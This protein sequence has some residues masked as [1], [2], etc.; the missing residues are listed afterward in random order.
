MTPSSKLP[1][2]TKLI[3]AVGNVGLLAL[4][5]SSA[6]FLMMFYTDI[7]LVPPAI[8]ASALLI[9]KIW[10]VFNDP[11][12]GYLSDHTNSRWGRRRVYLVYG[13]IPLFFATILLWSVPPGLTP[14]VAFIWI[15]L[16]YMI[17]DTVFTMIQMPFS[18]LSAE[19]TEDYDERTSL[20]AISMI[21]ALIGFSLGSV[22]MPRIVATQ[23]NPSLGYLFAG[24][25]YGAIAGAAIAFVAWRIREPAHF[26]QGNK[27]SLRSFLSSMRIPFS[28]R[29]FILLV[30]AATLAR[31]GLTLIQ[32][33][34]MYYVIYRLGM[35]KE[36]VP[37]LMGVLMLVILLFIFVWKLVC[38]HWNKHMAY[39]SGLL[40]TILSL[41]GFVIL[42]PS[43]PRLVYAA[44]GA[45]GIGLSA[46][47][48]APFAMLPDAVDYGR[49]QGALRQTGIY[50]AIYGLMDK[51]AR[52]LGTVSIGWILA[53]Y[54]YLPNVEQ[55]ERAQFGIDLMFGYLPAALLLLAIP[56][57]LRYPISRNAHAQMRKGLP[58]V[59][60]PSR[61][62]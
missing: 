28:N 56:Q 43:D 42:H 36:N 37:K 18:M 32:T 51:I 34:L 10:D 22:V 41:L 16:S 48:V 31:L 39:V 57:L 26:D 44:F 38:D 50:F 8:A 60:T 17:F 24:A 54:G 46:Q 19:L 40:L 7:A 33:S 47:W 2:G 27:A 21:G 9:G 23:A 1:L 14:T 15:A 58:A 52:T 55:T 35:G 45:I 13:A 61:F 49:K 59:D 4:M 12:F 53:W 5:S 6:F 20:I 25:L 30:S 11:L 29:P 3:Y 62:L